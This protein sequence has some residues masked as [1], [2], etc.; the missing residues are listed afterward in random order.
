MTANPYFT[1]NAASAHRNELLA[2]ANN[3]RLARSARGPARTPATS[4]RPW[5]G[6][7]RRMFGKTRVTVA[8]PAV[9]AR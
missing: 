5:A 1:A 8:T 7:V 6:V 9:G 2:A 4:A 3:A